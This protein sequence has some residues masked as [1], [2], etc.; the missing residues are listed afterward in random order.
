MERKE[1]AR[2]MMK[3]KEEKKERKKEGKQTP[4]QPY[5]M[6]RARA[7]RLFEKLRRQKSNRETY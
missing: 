2:K 7:P 1:K 4:T 3:K 5:P 6:K